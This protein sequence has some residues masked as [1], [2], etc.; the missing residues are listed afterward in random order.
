MIEEI[1]LGG[2]S[3]DKA[4]PKAAKPA[5][6]AAAPVIDTMDEKVTAAAE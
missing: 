6:K 4:A 1:I 3:I 5:A 2:K